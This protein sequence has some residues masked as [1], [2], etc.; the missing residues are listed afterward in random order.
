MD[1]AKRILSELPYQL[2]CLEVLLAVALV[3]VCLLV[4]WG[5]TEQRLRVGTPQWPGTEETNWDKVGCGLLLAIAIIYGAIKFLSHAVHS[6][7]YG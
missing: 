6:W 3:L 7:L 1:Q 2:G 4:W 5:K